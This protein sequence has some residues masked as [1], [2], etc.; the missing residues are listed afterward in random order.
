MRQKICDIPVPC[1]KARCE[2]VLLRCI[3]PR[4][5]RPL[6][7]ML[8]PWLLA[9]AGSAEFASMALPGAARALVDP[10]SRPVLLQALE[11][12]TG[13][14]EASRLVIANH[15]DCGMY[16]G[17]GVHD[18]PDEETHFHA[19]QLRQAAAV[20]RDAYPHLQVVLL[21]QDWDGVHEVS[22]GE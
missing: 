22:L 18:N 1:R 15:A 17:S 13:L 12:A 6:E 19:E 10:T 3:D 11:L 5:H 4:F 20:V 14:L 7:E 9:S 16:G 21:Y 2:A 8:G